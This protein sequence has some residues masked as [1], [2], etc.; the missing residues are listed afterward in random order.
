MKRDEPL[1]KARAIAQGQFDTEVQALAAAEATV[2]AARANITTSQASVK[3]AQA[4]VK[5]A[6][7]G[8]VAAKANVA[9]AELNLSFTQVRSLVDGIAGH[10][11]NADR[12]SGEDGHR[13][14]YRISSGP[15]SRLLPDQRERVPRLD[16][17]EG[18]RSQG[19]LSK[20]IRC[21]RTG[22]H[23]WLDVSA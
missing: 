5:S 22:A 20:P 23:R 16:D 18:G 8:V 6:Q 1:A 12:Q 14:D 3:S 9:Q 13:A 11:A 7:A 17:D 10:C 4:G 15:D 2:K 21:A 19:P